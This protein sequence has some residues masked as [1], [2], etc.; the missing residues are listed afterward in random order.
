VPRHDLD[1]ISLMA[2]VAFIGIAVAA[3]L[4]AGPRLPLRWVVPALLILV[5]VGGR[6]ATGA[7][8]R[9]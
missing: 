5:G 9:A 2:G 6:V 7:R 3:L 4:H 8:R 1:A